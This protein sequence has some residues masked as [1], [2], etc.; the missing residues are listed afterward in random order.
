MTST[1]AF[2]FKFQGLNAE[3]TEI[4]LSRISDIGAQITPTE[5]MTRLNLNF[6]FADGSSLSTDIVPSA[7]VTE[8]YGIVPRWGLERSKNNSVTCTFR[9]WPD[10][11]VFQSTF[12][13]VA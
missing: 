1:V 5:Q 6:T 11:Q 13:V 12:K 9:W 3:K 2:P 10:G 8:T 7:N 4:S